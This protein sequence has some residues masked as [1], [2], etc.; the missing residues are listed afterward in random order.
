MCT[1]PLFIITASQEHTPLCLL[2]AQSPR[3]ALMNRLVSIFNSANL[4]KNHIADYEMSPKCKTSFSL[5]L[6]SFST[7]AVYFP[8]LTTF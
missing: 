3:S 7:S 2:S 8:F 5:P 4:Y 6:P 1:K